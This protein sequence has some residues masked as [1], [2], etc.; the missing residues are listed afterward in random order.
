MTHP[1]GI[2]KATIVNSTRRL[3]SPS[4][5]QAWDSPSQGK[6]GG[7]L[8]LASFSRDPALD[9]GSGCFIRLCFKEPTSRGRCLAVGVA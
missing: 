7:E 6:K 8:K 5:I 3:S 9:P 1:A 4:F 2:P